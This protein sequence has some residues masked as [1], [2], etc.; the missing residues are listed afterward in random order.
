MTQVANMKKGEVVQLLEAEGYDLIAVSELQ[1]NYTYTQQEMTDGTLAADVLGWMIGLSGLII[2][3]AKRNVLQW[4][5]HGI[6]I[7]AGNNM[8]ALLKCDVSE[9][10]N[11]WAYQL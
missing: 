11:S 8:F 3:A 1:S 5:P 7:G 6:Y 10:G 9:N 2:A 4:M